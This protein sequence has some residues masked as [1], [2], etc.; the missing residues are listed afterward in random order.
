MHNYRIVLSLLK[1]TDSP[2]CFTPTNI[3]TQFP[4][5]TP[6]QPLYSDSTPWQ[7]QHRGGKSILLSPTFE[8]DHPFDPNDYRFGPIT[9]DWLDTRPPAKLSKRK[10]RIKKLEM[11]ASHSNFASVSSMSRGTSGREWSESSTA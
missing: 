3:F 2:S 1:K 11:A 4:S 9:I 5:H 8:N 10:D 7:L 6:Q